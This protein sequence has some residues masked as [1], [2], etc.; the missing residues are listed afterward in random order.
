MLDEKKCA[1]NAG[2]NGDDFLSASEMRH[3]EEVR[4]AKYLG[5]TAEQ[6]QEALNLE[7][8]RWE[9]L[10]NRL[11][12]EISR[13]Y[14]IARIANETRHSV[15]SI[16]AWAKNFDYF[17][18]PRHIGADS[19]A[20]KIEAALEAWF[21]DI[22]QERANE[23]TRNPAPIETSVTSRVMGAISMSREMV[24]IVDISAPPGSGKT[25][26]VAE[27]TARARKEEGFDCP[28]WVVELKEFGLCAKSVLRMIG[29]ACISINYDGHDD[30]AMFQEISDKTQ[31][32]GG[33][34]IIE[35]AQHLVDAKNG[36]GFHIFNGL[37][38]FVDARCFGI[39]LIGNG[40]LYRRLK[41]GQHA[42]LLSRM[43]SFR[44]EIP[45]I[46]EADVDNLMAAWGVNGKA[47]REACLRIAKGPGALR[48]LVHAFKRTLY[49]Y[50]VINAPALNKVPK[51]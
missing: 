45:G 7:V 8:A 23:R 46:T 32:R 29:R 9:W 19:L 48:S 35:E 10:K 47:E 26:G 11:A 22:E 49:D 1:V 34:L 31:G 30:D 17:R 25:Q 41:T 50:G 21:N 5:K 12:D 16:N 6:A 20:V 27:Y 28:V 39:V 38:R 44:V 43:A 42:Q 51:G 33:V 13:G 18:V 3:K 24:E 36:K 40:E 2:F 14:S 37:R 4:A 15:E